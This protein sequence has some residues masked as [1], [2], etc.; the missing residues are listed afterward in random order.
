MLHIGCHLSSSKGFAAMGRQALDMGADTFQFFTRN[1]RGSR[2][3]ALDLEDI[4]ALE[5]GTRSLEQVLS[6]VGAALEKKD[7]QTQHALELCRQ[8]RADRPSWDS[9]QPERYLFWNPSFSTQLPPVQDAS[10]TLGGG[11]LPVHW[12]IR[13]A[14]PCGSCFCLRCSGSTFCPPPRNKIFWALSCLWA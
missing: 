2:A 1:P 10:D 4:Q 14:S 11:T 5:Q 12:T 7:A 8:L 9:L 6:E 13:Y 3:K